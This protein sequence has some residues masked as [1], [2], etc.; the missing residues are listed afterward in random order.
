MT[1]EPI[2]KCIY[3]QGR[4]KKIVS[5]SS[6]H[7]KGSGWYITDYKKSGS[8]EGKSTATRKTEKKENKNVNIN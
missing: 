2:S 1:A 6:F 3:C 8:K 4:A 5:V 7:F